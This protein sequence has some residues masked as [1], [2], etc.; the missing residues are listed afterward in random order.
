V[1]AA[2]GKRSDWNRRYTE[3]DRHTTDVPNAFLVAEVAGLAPGRA[4]DLACGAGRNAV[5]LA[6][7]G[8]RVT[9]VDFSDAALSIARRRAA[10]RK[11]EVDWIEADVVGWRPESRAF[12]LVCVLYLQVPAAERRVVLSHAAEAVAPG[13]TLLVLGHDLLN[14]T[15]GWGGPKQPEVLFTPGDVVREIGDLVA[16][17]AERVRRETEDADGVH[18]AIDALVR[19]RRARNGSV[20]DQPAFSLTIAG[21]HPRA[22]R[23]PEAPMSD[24]AK[25]DLIA[26]WAFDTRP[27]LLRFHLWLEDVEVERAQP[28]PVSAFTFTP[29][30]IARCLAM[31]SAATALGTRLFG[32]FG[33]GAGTDKVTYNQVKKSAD[34]VSAYLMSEGLWHLTRTLPE[35]HAIMVSLGEGLMPKAGETPEMGANPMLGFGR[36]YA[37][38][39]VAR[40][41]DHGVRQLLNEPGRTFDD[42]YGRLQKEGIT[43]WGAAVDTLEN[44]SRF[45]EGKATG[46]MAVFHLFDS[47]LR[48]SRPYESYMGCLTLPRR[49]AEAAER[50]SVLLDYR[51]PRKQVAEAIEAAYPGIRREHVHVWTLRGKSRQGRLGK[52]WE[53]WAALGVHLVEDGWKAPSGLEVFTDSGTYAPTF[54]VGSW[55]D[56]ADATHV[57]LCDGYAA[58]AEAM[59]AAS[60]SDVL[61][62]D[63]TMSVFSPAFALPSDAEGRLMQLDPSAPDFAQRLAELFGGRRVEAGQVRAYAEAIREAEASNMP[64]DRRV[65]RPDDFLPEKKWQ[66]LACVGYMCDDPYTGTPGVTQ[67]ADGVYRVTTLLATRKASSRITFT[68]RLMDPLEQTRHVF[69]PLLVRFL[70]GADHTTR[71]VKISDSGRI[72]NELQTMLSQALEHD[73]DKIR[74]HFDRVDDRVL[75]PAKQAAIRN[76]LEWYK[77]NHPVWFAWLEVA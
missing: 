17:K 74:V 15:E 67:V 20:P 11:V 76:V 37:R 33:A 54:L 31:T 24:T 58:T 63:S 25:R 50:A 51:T 38:P 4:L 56:G 45:A 71:P 72:R 69:S 53:E 77:A 66:V 34:A 8:W 36:V 42:F 55:K 35:N 61:D 6:E 30:G 68:F 49:V 48:L 9:A 57:F 23:L 27:V 44:T 64:L 21:R 19:A 16:D 2:G 43:V 5:W 10:E 1:T 3:G 46:P 73:G 7:Q 32:Q 47:P 62:V 28:E 14:L 12:D 39:G 26:Q 22:P 65:L 60:L 40:I 59:Q 52:L 41:V 29:R 13:G 18:V 70:N 75:P